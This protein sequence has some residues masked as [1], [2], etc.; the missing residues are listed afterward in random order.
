MKVCRRSGSTAPL[1]T[2]LSLRDEWSTSDPGR[3]NPGK[4]L[5]ACG[6]GG[7]LGSRAGLEVSERRKISLLPFI[8]L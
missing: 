8:T 3:F 2:I 1:I 5:G 6:I 7:W 4:C